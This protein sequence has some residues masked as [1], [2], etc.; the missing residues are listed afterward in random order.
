MKIAIIQLSDIHAQNNSVAE[1]KFISPIVN[2]LSELPT[3]NHVVIVFSGDISKSGKKEQYEAIEHFIGKLIVQIRSRFLNDEEKISVLMVPGNHDINFNVEVRNRTDII[4]LVKD[5]EKNL[6]KEYEMLEGF[7]TLANKNDCFLSDKLVD[8]KIIDFNGVKI[9]FNLINSAVFST[10]NDS[11]GDNEKELHVFPKR[12]SG[13]LMKDRS[14]SLCVTVVHHNTEW[15]NWEDRETLE[16]A[17]SSDSSI[18]LIGHDHRSRTEFNTIDGEKECLVIKG[19]VF[20]DQCFKDK[21]VTVLY[22]T[23]E[24]KFETYIMEKETEIFAVLKRDEKHIQ[25]PINYKE[26]YLQKK[27]CLSIRDNFTDPAIKA[28]YVFPTLQKQNVE[29]FEK[30]T[31]IEDFDSFIKQLEGKEICYIEGLDLAGRTSLL[32]YLYFNSFKNT[33][34]LMISADDIGKKDKLKDVIKRNFEKQFGDDRELY[35]KFLQLGREEKTLYFDDIDKINDYK[36]MLNSLSNEYGLIIVSLRPEQTDLKDSVIYEVDKNKENIKFTIEPFYYEKRKELIK[37]VCLQ[38]FQDCPLETIDAK[39][40]EINEFIMEQLKVFNISPYFIIA[41]CNSYYRQRDISD[42]RLNTFSEVFRVDMVNKFSQISKIRVETAFFILEEV[43]Q[44]IFENTSYPLSVSTFSD[45]VASYNKKYD[46]SVNSIEFISDLIESKIIKYDSNST[47]IRFYSDSNLAYFI[48]K[49]ICDLSDTEKSKESI[50]Y[51]TKHL[52]FGINCEI[53]MFIISI[54]NDWNSL[55]KILKEISTEN[56]KWEEFD[57]SKRNIEFLTRNINEIKLRTPTQKDKKRAVTSIEKQERK[58]KKRQLKT[59]NIFDY[60]EKDLDKQINQQICATKSLYVVAS[61]Y[62]NFYHI[63]PAENKNL[64]LDYIFQQ[65]NKIIYFMLKPFDEKFDDMIQEIYDL[66]VEIDR[67]VKKEDII[68]T[69]VHV[70]SLMVLNVYDNVARRVGSDETL[71]SLKKYA[72]ETKNINYLLELTMVLENM[73]RL[74]EFGRQA[75]EIEKMTKN[76]LIH[77]MIKRIVHKHFSWNNVPLVGYGQKL[78][79][80]YFNNDKN[81]I[82]KIQNRSMR[83]KR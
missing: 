28:R 61:M 49:K 66:I 82:R 62:A 65:P 60:S 57:F 70:G 26:F 38:N 15:F 53:L 43:A 74:E 46:Q 22:D 25:L 14:A 20:N 16:K 67:E 83:K 11:L 48:A 58:I 59:I 13:L 23:D 10:L 47:Y 75:E 4:S 12:Y 81:S 79:Q 21:F 41:Y 39:V 7:Y 73:S 35:S 33:L 71:N 37:K 1:D 5:S 40:K 6:K 31:V 55:N 50:R 18:L 34:P 8:Q 45:I 9:Q 80:K 56:K 30:N 29:S 69:V 44:Y 64:F 2:S 42:N 24:H 72:K 17:I 19:G 54:R 76:K 52:C 27:Y 32:N 77:D 78:A 63:I 68:D 36:E 51:L 3:F